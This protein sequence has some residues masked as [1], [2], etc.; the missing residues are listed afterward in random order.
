MLIIFRCHCPKP[1]KAPPKGEKSTKRKDADA[2]E[3]DDEEGPTDSA[4][5][6]NPVVDDGK[7]KKPRQPSKRGSKRDGKEKSDGDLG[8]EKEAETGAEHH[9]AV[10][11]QK[12]KHVTADGGL[13]MPDVRR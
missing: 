6:D 5:K 13:F 2:E 1:K 4:A 9:A 12:S 10:V 3:R 11:K 8:D 7:P